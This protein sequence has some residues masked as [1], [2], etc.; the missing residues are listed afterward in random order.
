MG[1]RV[2]VVRVCVFVRILAKQA[3]AGRSRL[4]KQDVE[5]RGTGRRRTRAIIC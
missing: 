1:S 3:L 4:E 2:G 5:G